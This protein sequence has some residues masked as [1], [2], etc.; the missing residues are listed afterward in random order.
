VTYRQFDWVPV[1]SVLL[2]AIFLGYLARAG[3]AT[4]KARQAAKSAKPATS[5]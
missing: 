4:L 5:A 1:V 2:V 3:L